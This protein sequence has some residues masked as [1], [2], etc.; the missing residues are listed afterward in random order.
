MET[1]SLAEFA[2]LENTLD[3]TQGCFYF[4]KPKAEIIAHDG[5][6]LAHALKT[7]A[8]YQAQGCYLVGYISYEAS[9][10]LKPG[11]SHL[12]SQNDPK[13][14]LHFTAFEQLSNTIPEA[15]SSETYD[16]S[17]P[18]ISLLKDP[19]SF[20]AY[21]EK[22]QSITHALTRGDSYQ[23]NFTK[24]IEIESAI[25]SWQL[26]QTLKK[27]QPVAYSA[28]LPFKPKTVLSFSPELFFHKNGNKIM[29]KPMKGTSPRSDNEKKDLESRLFL[30]ND[31]KNRAENLIIVD[32]LR[33][34]LASFCDVGS[35]N[36]ERAFDIESYQSVYQMTS[37]VSARCDISTSFSQILSHLFPCGSITGAPKRRTMEIIHDLETPRGIYTGSIGYI[38]PNNDMCFN[39]AIRTIEYPHTH[40]N[41]A[42]IGVGG[43]ITIKSNLHD[44][45]QEMNMKLRFIQSAYR[46]DFDLIETLYFSQQSK[47]RSLERHL[48][49]LERSAQLFCF[50][51][52]K[53]RLRAQLIEYAQTLDNTASYKIRLQ[54]Q[55]NA[56]A[57]ITHQ[58]LIADSLQFVKTKLC[59]EKIQSDNI[60]WQHKTT[61][62]STRGFYQKMHDKYTSNDE[63]M[64]LLYVNEQGHISEARFYNIIAVIDGVSLT[65]PITD[66]L[67]PGILREK[68]IESGEII[69]KSITAK[70]LEHAQSLYLINDVRGKIPVSFLSDTDDTSKQGAQHDFI[71]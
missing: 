46:S 17:S 41:H 68:L 8:L 13:P 55:N 56:D 23:I 1:L 67:L 14:L 63:N 22:Y 33:N 30:Q 15:L 60:L 64:E 47:F 71:S 7:I 29:V 16:L 31:N 65:P 39:V 51:F 48:S 25:N 2:L 38:M 6:T 28:Y 61:H 27:N 59:P 54:L 24:R 4:S 19:L 40:N 37:T 35:I 26:Y 52:D 53:N 43:G 49:R 21:Q 20:E 9:Y 12:Q 45:Y 57:T 70:M 66:G 44:E 5:S 69:E 32:L 42:Q 34:D 3:H 36:V 62:P 10:Y 18:A 11:L 58:R 50:Q